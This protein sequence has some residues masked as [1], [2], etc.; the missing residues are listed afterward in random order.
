MK[1]NLLV[2]QLSYNGEE[3]TPTA[4]QLISYSP[5]SFNQN[6]VELWDNENIQLDPNTTYW[7]K[8]DGLNQINTIRKIA[9]RINLNFLLTQDILNINHPSKIEEYENFLL[10]VLKYFIVDED[11]AEYIPFQISIVLG[12]NY[13]ISFSE[14]KHPFMDDIIKAIEND[15]FHIRKRGADYLLS[16]VINSIIGNHTSA[17]LQINDSLDDLEDDLLSFST[18]KNLG[19]EIQTTRK[20]YIALKKADLPLKDQYARLF[21][22]NNK[23]ISPK[24]KAFFNDVNDHLQFVLQNIDICRET[25]ASLVDLYISNND[26]KMNDIMKRLTIVSTIF[27]PLTFLVGVWGMNFSFMPELDWKYGYIVAWLLMIVIGIIIYIYFKI[28]KWY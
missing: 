20:Q 16:V 3:L 23:L 10:L 9:D 4:V 6:E 1:N 11:S 12:D 19:I 22:A 25:L 2:E 24:N 15:V 17:I 21:R 13:L 7:V 18:N 27:I 8:V 26:L 14:K 5:T 28:K